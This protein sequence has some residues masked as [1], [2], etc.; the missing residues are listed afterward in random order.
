MKT[1][2]SISTRGRFCTDEPIVKFWLE[3]AWRRENLISDKHS[4][5]QSESVIHSVVLNKIFTLLLQFFSFWFVFPRALA[6]LREK[7]HNQPDRRSHIWVHRLVLKIYSAIRHGEEGE[8]YSLTVIMSR[9]E[10]EDWNTTSIEDVRR[11]RNLQRLQQ[12]DIQTLTH[13]K[14][15]TGVGESNCMWGKIQRS[16]LWLWRKLHVIW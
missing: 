16:L 2:K 5:R 10:D 1:R 9:N 15:F 13:I 11:R 7:R 3:G 8:V 14:V 6:A 12:P 4:V